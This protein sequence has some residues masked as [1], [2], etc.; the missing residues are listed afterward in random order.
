MVKHSLLFH[1]SVIAMPVIGTYRVVKNQKSDEDAL[2]FKHIDS[3][4][5]VQ[6]S[7]DGRLLYQRASD[8]D[9]YWTYVADIQAV[10]DENAWHC[11]FTY[12]DADLLIQRVGNSMKIGEYTSVENINTDVVSFNDT[13]RR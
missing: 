10:I 11:T 9:F 8:V 6:I 12:F 1:S 13:A 3:G 4:A 5:L 7:S 2:I